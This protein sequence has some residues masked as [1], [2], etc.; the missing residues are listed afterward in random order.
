MAG[1]DRQ[2][3][4]FVYLNGE[5]MPAGEAV[6]PVRDRGFAYG[7][8]LIE[9]MKLS[10]GRPVF[11]A[12]HHE[13][14]RSACSTTGIAAPPEPRALWHA[15]VS[16]AEANRVTAGRLRLQLTRGV[17]PV[18]EGPDP[19]P[20]HEPTLLITAE[21]FA[22]YPGGLYREGMSLASVRA[23]RGAWAHLKTSSLMTT[24]MA[25]REALLA[26]ADEALFTS[27]HGGLLEGS[28]TN[29]FFIAR[30]SCRTAPPGDR[31]LPGVVRGKVM[32]I[33]AELG[34][35]V[36]ERALNADELDGRVAAFLTGSLLG[37]CPVKRI[38]AQ[39]LHLDLPLAGRAA[40]YL[41][42]LERESLSLTY[43]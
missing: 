39:E 16:L 2:P 15:C 41:E 25:R 24:I 14:L 17:P 40:S 23:D 20:R 33:L 30:G 11:F 7:D 26:G 13:R 4:G 3:P 12:E 31:I 38:D 6:V 10:G 1:A 19:G 22:G 37:I 42:Q 43:G 9:T 36:E 35:K 5:L 29:I 34:L 21:P 32:G 27:A 18:P 28:Y 8:A